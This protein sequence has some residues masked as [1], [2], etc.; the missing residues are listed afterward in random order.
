MRRFVPFGIVGLIGLVAAGGQATCAA[1]T[2]ITVVVKNDFGCKVLPRAGL[3]VAR[4]VLELDQQA[5]TS[6]SFECD[7]SGRLGSIVLVPKGDKSGR[8]ALQI[9]LRP[10]GE[11]PANCLGANQKGCIFARRDLAWIE[12]VNLEVIVDMRLACLDIP[13]ERSATC[14][15]GNCVSPLLTCASPPCDESVL[16]SPRN[17]LDAGVAEAEAGQILPPKG[18]ID[19]LLATIPVGQWLELPNTAMEPA[20]P[21]AT[22]GN[23]ARA[24]CSIAMAAAGGGAF[25]STRDR[26]LVTGGG[27]GSPLNNVYAFDLA[28][29]TW[30]RKTDVP[31]G[32]PIESGTPSLGETTVPNYLRRVDVEVCGYYPK[33]SIETA[34]VPATPPILND[35]QCDA[36]QEHLDDQQPRAAQ[37]FGNFVYR[38]DTD[39]VC[40]T[41]SVLQYASSGRSTEVSCLSQKSFLWRRAGRNRFVGAGAAAIDREGRVWYHGDRQVARLEGDAFVAKSASSVSSFLKAVGDIDRKR[42]AFL[43]LDRSSQAN[44]LVV[45][46]LDDL[47]S[48]PEELTGPP[49]DV[50]ADANPALAYVDHLDRAYA[51]FGGKLLYVFDPTSKTWTKTEPG[52]TVNPGAPQTDGTYGRFAY[53]KNRKL[54]LVVNRI[55]ANVFVYKLP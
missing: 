54:L 20:C 41:G 1:P 50:A 39:E 49:L 9:A 13:C 47:A 48:A 25:D 53:S 46:S 31:T 12:N 26:L 3:S 8:I 15:R 55:D 45:R 43:I 51:W 37:M 30:L 21:R 29:M 35:T 42:N 11:D 5:L 22:V 36:L 52:G 14:V 23:N 18:P 24:F 4:T 7:A 17:V 28:T 10:D 40:R 19:D 2:A 34:A 38:A 44:R 32:M 6:T 33:R 27:A 16:L